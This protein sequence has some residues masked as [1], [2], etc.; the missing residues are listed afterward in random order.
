MCKIACGSALR[1]EIRP[2]KKEDLTGLLALEEMC[3][4][5]EIFK[6]EQLAY[7]LLKAKSLVFVATVDNILIGSI[8]VLLRK[9]IAAARIY[10]LNVHPGCRRKG[11]AGLLMDTSEKSLKEMGFI[12]VTL[13]VGVHNQTAQDLYRSKGFS[14]DKTLKK[15]YKNMSN[16]L[17]MTKEL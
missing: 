5:E 6:K 12:K 9:N 4:K 17:H 8:I 1:P 10:S 16:A 7:L 13:E 3:F 2:A 15:Y 11:L 14:V